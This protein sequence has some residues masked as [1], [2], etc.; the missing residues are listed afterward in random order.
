[1]TRFVG[2][3]IHVIFGHRRM[4]CE[5]SMIVELTQMMVEHEPMTHEHA[6]RCCQCF[7]DIM[8]QPHTLT[9]AH[10]TN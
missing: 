10:V 4:T 1:M 7:P 8:L 6:C 9:V 5:C 3:I 2:S